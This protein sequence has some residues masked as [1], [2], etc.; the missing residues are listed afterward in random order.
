MN[1]PARLTYRQMMTTA[2]VLTL[3]AA[4]TVP[5]IADGTDDRPGPQ[6]VE[7]D[8]DHDAARR[9]VDSGAALTLLE[10]KRIVGERV[11]GEIVSVKL[12]REDH[13]LVYEFRILTANGRLVEAEV[14]AATG[15]ILE[16]E[17]E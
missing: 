16:V 4:L 12:D 11:P 17:N 7:A 1:G 10:L 15:A 14:D 3:L 8:D 6:A 9:A 13:K 2:C 5:A